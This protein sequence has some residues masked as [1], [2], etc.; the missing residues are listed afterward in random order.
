ML[1]QCN[2]QLEESGKA[3]GRP[4]CFYWRGVPISR[5][6]VTRLQPA[7]PLMEAGPLPPTP[8]PDF[9][10]VIWAMEG[11]LQVGPGC[12]VNVEHAHTSYC[13]TSCYA[14]YA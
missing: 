14:K 4:A 10:T 2:M 5:S 9:A 13:M 7:L 1:V 11:Y 6:S 12:H 3:E 8:N